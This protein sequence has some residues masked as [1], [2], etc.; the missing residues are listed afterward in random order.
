MRRQKRRHQL[1]DKAKFI[2]KGLKWGRELPDKN[3]HFEE[4]TGQLFYKN[5]PIKESEISSS[6]KAQLGSKKWAK[7]YANKKTR[8]GEKELERVLK[9]TKK[10]DFEN[11]NFDQAAKTHEYSKSIAWLIY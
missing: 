1:R 4:G 8:K 6:Y 11:N 3:F 5:R 9:E 7:R 10:E 2:N